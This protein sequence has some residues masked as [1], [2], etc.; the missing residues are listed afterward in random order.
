MTDH[1]LQAREILARH[2][3]YPPPFGTV[4]ATQA[5]RA[6]VEA[7][8]HKR[9]EDDVVDAGREAYEQGYRDGFVDHHV[10]EAGEWPDDDGES[11]L[12]GLDSTSLADGWQNHV[13]TFRAAITAL[14]RGSDDEPPRV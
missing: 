1:S 9:S 3:P 5:E 11:L 4:T 7:L 6:I 8:S 10:R 2:V 14:D 12:R 13:D